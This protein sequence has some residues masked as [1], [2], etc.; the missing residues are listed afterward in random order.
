[1]DNQNSGNGSSPNNNMQGLVENVDQQAEVPANLNPG[2]MVDASQDDGFVVISNA[3]NQ[4]NSGE[5]NNAEGE[6]KP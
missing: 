1:M 2:A 4:I 3:L 6:D 5:A